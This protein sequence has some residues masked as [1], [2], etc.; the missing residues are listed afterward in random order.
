MATFSAVY[1][2]IKLTL[3]ARRRRFAAWRIVSVHTRRGRA[4]VGS[5]GLP[6]LVYSLCMSLCEY[7]VYLAVRRRRIM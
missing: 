3:Q 1:I 5:D 4:Q 7:V 6:L 2:T